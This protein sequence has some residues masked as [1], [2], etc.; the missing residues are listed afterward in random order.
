MNTC[1]PGLPAVMPEF[2]K[3]PKS[4]MKRKPKKEESDSDEEWTPYKS[5][6]GNLRH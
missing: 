5:S 4:R 3:G 1:F 6:R 2:M